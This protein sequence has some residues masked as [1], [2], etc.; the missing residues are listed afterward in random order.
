MKMSNTIPI[1]CAAV[2]FALTA[3]LNAQSSTTV[4]KIPAGTTVP[5]S[6]HAVPQPQTAPPARDPEAPTVTATGCLERWRGDAAAG[7]PA[8]KGPAGVT[9]VLTRIHGETTSASAGESKTAATSPQARYLLLPDPKVDYAAHL[10]HLV[11][12]AGTIAPQPSAGASVGDAIADPAT[13]ETNLPA[14]EK[15]EA[16]Q[17]NLIE[18]SAL[19]MVARTCGH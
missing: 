1:W 3:G 12:I 8:D 6:G 11:K 10:N 14:D 2:A 17:D 13:R 4:P 19:T 15:S 18:V 5:P 16:Y 7:V 9:F